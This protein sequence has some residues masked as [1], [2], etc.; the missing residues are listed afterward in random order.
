VRLVLLIAVAGALGAVARYGLGGLVHKWAGAG[1]PWGTLI[2]NLL[3]CF[4]LGLLMR[5]SL[6]NAVSDETRLMIGT[7]FLGA[8]TTFSTF[9]YETLRLLET[10][11]FGLAAANAAGSLILGLGCVWLGGVAARLI[12]GGAG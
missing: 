6:D 2:V 9:G 5:L 10:G 11:A 8:F 1:F 12:T 3:G 4:A 7:G